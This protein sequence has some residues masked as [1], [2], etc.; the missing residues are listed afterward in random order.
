MF[1]FAWTFV[2]SETLEIIGLDG[3][4]S[5]G[6]EFYES[7]SSSFVSLERMEIENMKEWEEWECKT[8]FFPSSISL[9][10]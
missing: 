9:D 2:I 3:I 6:A 1:A 4:L 10:Y 5:I 7:S 8:N